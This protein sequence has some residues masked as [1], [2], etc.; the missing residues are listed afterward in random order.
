M[1]KLFLC[2]CNK[3]LDKKLDFPRI[4][5]ELKDAF[6]NVQIHDALCL[7]E[8]LAFLE[9]EVSNKDSVVIGA[10]TSQIIGMPMSKSLKTESVSFVP[11]REHVAWVHSDDLKGASNKAVV[12]LRDAA[13]RVDHMEPPT[14]VENHMEKEVL[15]VGGGMCGLKVAADLLHLGIDVTILEPCPWDDASYVEAGQFMADKETL[16]KMVKE[17]VSATA[18]ATT[19]CCTITGLEGRAGKYGVSLACLDDKISTIACG[20]IVFA[21]NVEQKPPP[22]AK[23]LLYGKSDRTILLGDLATLLEK[24]GPKDVKTVMVAV[25]PTHHLSAVEGGYLLR[26]VTEAAKKGNTVIVAHSNIRTEDENIYR[27]ARESGVIFVRGALEKIKDTKDGLVCRLE[28]TLESQVREFVVD[29]LV[30]Q[31]MTRPRRDTAVLAEIAGLSLDE[32]GFITTR[33]SKNKPVQTSKKGIY[34][35]GNA[36][37]PMSAGDAIASAGNAA[38]EVF[39]DIRTATRRKGWIPIIDEEQCDICEA[40]I[41][42]CPNDALRLVDGKVTHISQHCEFCGICV[43]ACPTRAIEFQSHSKESW[44][45]RFEALA[46]NHKK[47]EGDKPFTFV[48]A[49]SECANASIDLAGF[50]GKGYPTGT[51]VIQFPC[52]GMVSPIEILK[53]L[54]VG[55]ERI[56]VAHCPP[57]GCHHQTGDHMAELVVKFTQDMLRSIGQDPERVKATYMIAALPNK[58]QEEVAHRG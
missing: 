24:Q 13:I 48:Y 44:F 2:T 18:S 6:D 9:S 34:I 33:Y 45:A 12:L 25:D 58:M 23:K 15:I 49:C 54:A 28:N 57:G 14:V 20:S 5:K 26:V 51:Y 37:M 3:T 32:D 56:V 11:L 22:M 21:T 17:L 53:G 36:K 7:K 30:L 50:T 43:S 19:I 1:K 40:C 47:M 38:L 27:A 41:E 52:A 8:G 35:A 46:E 55:A 31:T 39:K 10:C 42:A 29:L 4:E 16:T